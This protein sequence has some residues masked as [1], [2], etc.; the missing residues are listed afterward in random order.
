MRHLLFATA[1]LAPTLVWAED[2]HDHHLAERDGFRAVH[3]WTRATDADEALVF[4][5]LENTGAGPVLIEGAETAIAD[6]ATLVGFTLTEG[7]PAYTALPP[8]P[9][10]PGREMHLDP[11]GM[12]I[13][14]TGLTGELS[15][16]DAFEMHLQTSLGE[17]GIDVAVEAADARHHSHAGHSH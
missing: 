6:S 1:L 10:G 13:L 11:D 12:A 2:G 4:V 9:V 15:K 17:I 8:L 16:G 7:E 3:A 5:D 14:L